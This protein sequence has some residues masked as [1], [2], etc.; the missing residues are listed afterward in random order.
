MHHFRKTAKKYNARIRTDCPFCDAE[1]L[2]KKVEDFE[3]S[4]I[5][6]NLTKYDLWELHEVVE[7]LLLVPKRHI[8]SIGDLEERE[9]LE[10][11]RIIGDYEKRGYNVYARAAKSERRSVIHQ[12]THLIKIQGGRAKAALYISKPH[13]LLKV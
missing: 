7:H 10:I 5:V 11:M 6:K 1:T 8:E 4:Y 2:S 12:H 9:Q 3:Y 13:I